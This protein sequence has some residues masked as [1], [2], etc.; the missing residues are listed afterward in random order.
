MTGRSFLP[1]NA[2]ARSSGKEAAKLV[3]AVLT[4][5]S[6][7]TTHVA[8][9]GL[10]VCFVVVR[11]CSISLDGGRLLRAFFVSRLVLTAQVTH[12]TMLSLFWNGA[13]G[14]SL[15]VRHSQYPLHPCQVFIAKNPGTRPGQCA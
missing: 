2:V 3:S 12:D 10:V 8:A 11:C 14:L 5:G 6:G 4:T 13:R 9:I 1:L 7:M 15:T